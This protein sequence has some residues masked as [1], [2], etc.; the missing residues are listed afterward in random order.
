M[1]CFYTNN[2]ILL[3]VGSK[4][5]GTYLWD[6]LLGGLKL[7]CPDFSTDNFNL[8]SVLAMGALINFSCIVLSRRMH[9][10]P[11]LWT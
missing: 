4:T 5:L 6:I 11:W 8:E 9:A 10:S 3:F 1:I 2:Y 7:K